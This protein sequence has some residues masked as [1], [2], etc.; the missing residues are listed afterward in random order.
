MLTTC[1]SSFTTPTNLLFGLLLFLPGSTIF[2]ILFPTNVACHHLCQSITSLN[3]LAVSVNC[4]TK[5]VPLIF[6]ILAILAASYKNFSILNST[7]SN[8]PVVS[9]VLQ[10]ADLE[11]SWFHKHPANFLFHS[12]RIKSIINNFIICDYRWLHC[13]TLICWSTSR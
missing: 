12:V 2:R 13:G 11:H 5:P 10:S 7:S 3:C 1:M 9:S 8:L 4:L 6:L